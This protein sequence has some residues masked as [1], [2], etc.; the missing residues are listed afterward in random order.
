VVEFAEGF[1]Y[2]VLRDE[3][4]HARETQ[5]AFVSLLEPAEGVRTAWGWP[6]H[7]IGEEN[8]IVYLDEPGWV[9]LVHDQNTTTYLWGDPVSASRKHA[10]L[11][12]FGIM[13]PPYLSTRLRRLGALPRRVSRRARRLLTSRGSR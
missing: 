2:D 8:E 11:R 6:H 5:N 9:A 10:V 12:E 13:P 3:I 1:Y 4:R 7:E